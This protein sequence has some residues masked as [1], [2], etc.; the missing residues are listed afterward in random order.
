LKKTRFSRRERQD[1]EMEGSLGDKR[2][3]WMKRVYLE[4]LIRDRKIKLIPFII[5]DIN[6]AEIG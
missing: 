1:V 4:M 6:A 3:I 2:K 5:F